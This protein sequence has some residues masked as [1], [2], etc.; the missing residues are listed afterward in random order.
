VRPQANLVE[1]LYTVGKKNEARDEFETLR[2]LAGM[3]DLDTPPLARLAPIARDLGLPTDW[4]RPQTIQQAL[5]KRRPLTSL[6]PLA[7]R[8]WSAPDWKLT[9]AQG[10]AH[11]L[12][13]FRGKPVVL[14]F[15]LGR[16]CLHCQQQLQAFAKKAEEFSKAGLTV[17]AVSTDDQ[18]GIKKSLEDFAP[19]PN[20]P[21]TSS[22]AS[23]AAREA[24]FPFLMLADPKSDVFRSYRAYDDF[25]Q[26]SLH[27]TFLIDANG[28]VRWHDVSFEPF[29]DAGFFLAEAQR[30][31]PLPVAPIEPDA[32]VLAWREH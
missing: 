21:G 26:I 20:V 22:A 23:S 30:L 29:L 27:G 28:F 15:F 11:T 7:W 1:V 24:G 12:S 18:R 17:I 10:R 4:R 31:L 32:R 6:G 19:K 2:D 13:E 3:A 9:D 16:G 8:P 25:E 5:A 14:L